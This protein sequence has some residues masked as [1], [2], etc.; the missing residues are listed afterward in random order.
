MVS[1]T[2]VA[3]VISRC[4]YVSPCR[5]AIRETRIRDAD[6][7]HRRPPPTSWA[8]IGERRWLLR[9]RP[10]QNTEA[11]RLSIRSKVESFR[12]EFRRRNEVGSAEYVGCTYVYFVWELRIY[13]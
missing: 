1:T 2:P 13:V 4:M 8:V 10:T 3:S 9:A 7:R 11:R 6:A 12:S 5:A